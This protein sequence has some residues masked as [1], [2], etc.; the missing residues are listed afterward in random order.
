ML[1][2]SEINKLVNDK[3]FKSTNCLIKNLLTAI[4]IIWNDNNTDLSISFT[5]NENGIGIRIGIL[6]VIYFIFKPIIIAIEIKSFKNEIVKRVFEYYPESENY[7]LDFESIVKG[8][9]YFWIE[10]DKDKI[11]TLENIVLFYLSDP[12]TK[13]IILEYASDDIECKEDEYRSVL[14]LVKNDFFTE[15][16]KI[17]QSTKEDLNNEYYKYI[18]KNEDIIKSINGKKED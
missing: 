1:K 14:Q 13:E 9:N 10:E 7:V 12:K 16:C 4:K 15:T 6:K 2:Y 18:L 17:L 5:L 11:Q 3:T 8:N